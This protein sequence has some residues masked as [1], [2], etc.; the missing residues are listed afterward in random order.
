MTAI[1][2]VFNII[3]TVFIIAIVALA[4]AMAFSVLQG[5]FG[6]RVFVVQSGSM[7][8]AIKTG[9]IVVV[10][11]QA[12]YQKKDIIT[13]LAEPK[14]NLKDPKS[15]VTHRIVKIN[16]KDKKKV[17]YIVQGDANN[18]ADRDPIPS[19]SVLGKVQIAV[20]LAGYAV[21]FTKTQTGFIMLVIV[22]ATLIV[23]SELMNIK[24]EVVRI[25]SKKKLPAKKEEDEKQNS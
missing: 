12:T 8:P 1:K 10:L 7:E 9:S 3:Y 18:A 23:Y 13:F 4:A 5:P 22:P 2:K 19:S 21:A 15:T 16:N 17:S 6:L 25:F 20:P 11:P 24:R 14:A